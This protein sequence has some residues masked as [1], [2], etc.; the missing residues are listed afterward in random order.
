M[1]DTFVSLA[2]FSWTLTV[3]IVKKMICCNQW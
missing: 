2:D 1:T 3:N